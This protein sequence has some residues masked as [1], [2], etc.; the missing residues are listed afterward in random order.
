M[1]TSST[2]AGRLFLLERQRQ[3]IENQQDLRT[4]QFTV[5]SLKATITQSEKKI[6]QITS[7]YRQQ[8][9][10]ERVDTAAQLHKL[11]Q[12]SEKQAHRYGLL[13][14]KA[15]HSG[16]IKDLATHTR[17]TVV[18][19]GT[20]LLTIVPQDE[21]LLAEVWIS[22][23]DAGFIIPG[24]A[25]RV[26]LAAYPFQKYGMLDGIV[27]H[28]SADASS[29]QEKNKGGEPAQDDALPA[30]GLNYLA[31]V[32]LN[33]PVLEAQGARLRLT[34]GMQVSAEILLGTRTVL[35]YL[36]SPIQKTVYEAARER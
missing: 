1:A 20:I 2:D 26:K 30:A 4:Q 14:L 16:I 25:V 5:A 22:N 6:A 8:L 10:N 27:R 11:E 18:Q 28:V 3:R 35:E 24:Q 32:E 21:P 19:P 31:L 17:G 29:A 23:L 12:D 13:E 36:L 34:P 15:Q 33:S 9:Q 7:A